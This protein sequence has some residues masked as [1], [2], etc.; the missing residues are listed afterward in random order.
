MYFQRFF[1]T[2]P[3]DV[4]EVHEIDI[5]AIARELSAY[6]LEHWNSRGSGLVRN[7]VIRITKFRPFKAPLTYPLQNAS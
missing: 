3:E 6:G 2:R 1:G 7:F 5:D 4:N